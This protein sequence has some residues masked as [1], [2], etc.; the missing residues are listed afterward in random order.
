MNIE[1]SNIILIRSWPG[2]QHIS[3][4]PT[5]IIQAVQYNIIPHPSSSNTSL[6]SRKKKNYRY[7]GVIFI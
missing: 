4:K 2:F 5:F 7:S 6:T 3:E 1:E